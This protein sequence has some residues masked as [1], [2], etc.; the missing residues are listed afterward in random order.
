[1]SIRIL[2]PGLLTTIQDKGRFGFQHQ[3]VIVSGAMDA[4]AQRMANLLVGNEDN[5]GVLEI[6]LIGPTMLFEADML[7]SVCGGDLSPAIGGAPVPLWRPVYIKAGATLEFGACR[8]GARAYVAVA[9]GIDV[10]KVMHSKSTFLRAG[11]GGLDG[12]ALQTGD[13]LR[14]GAPSAQA[15]HFADACSQRSGSRPFYAAEWFAGDGLLPAYAANPVVRIIRGRQ[16]GQFTEKS[17]Q[18]LFECEFKVTPQSDRMGYRLQGP[19]L[20]RNESDGPESI[21]EAVSFGTIQVPPD[22]S[23]IILMADSQTIGGYP[24][25]AQVTTVDLPVLAQVKPGETVSFAEVSLQEAE[26]LYIR[27]E[28]EIMMISKAISLYLKDCR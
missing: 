2:H 1:M 8:Q 12:R 27:R 5:E 3:G 7:I 20:E 15:A 19:V 13:V 16:F 9:G 26:R 21:S 25:I 14:H 6:T 24:K 11:L 22:G 28:R 23:P 18:L 10:P 17:K 4:F